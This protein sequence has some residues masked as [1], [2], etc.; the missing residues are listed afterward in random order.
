MTKQEQEWLRLA[1]AIT[2]GISDGDI[3][4]DMENCKEWGPLEDDGDALRLAVS[5]GMKLSIN[6]HH[7][8]VTC[9]DIQISYDEA[10]FGG[11]CDVNRAVRLAI[12]QAAAEIGKSME[13]N[14]EI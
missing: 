7:R 9:N 10:K 1:A 5:L 11:V 13:L 4:Y 2:P 8:F 3:F 6:L 14:H 12:V